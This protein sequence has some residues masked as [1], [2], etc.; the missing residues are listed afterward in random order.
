MSA[1]ITPSG[2]GL[3]RLGRAGAVLFPEA[4]R[5]VPYERWIN[6]AL[7][8]THLLASSILLGG[9][10]FG[11]PPP[12]LRPWLMLTLATGVGLI[13]LELYRTCQW[14]YMLQGVLVV[15]K[16]VLTALAGL[17]WEQRVVLL[18]LVVL[19]GSVGSHMSA[20]YRHYSVVH[21]RELTYPARER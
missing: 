15:G 17:W 8:S 1:R 5:R 2:A 16:I 12:I 3:G 4:P 13:M 9:H 20:R 18:S 14:V 21:G 6:I 11:M 19:V 10:T 7:R